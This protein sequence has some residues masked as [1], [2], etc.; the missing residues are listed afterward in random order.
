VGLGEITVEKNRTLPDASTRER[1]ILGTMAVVILFM[2]IASPLFTRRMEP[3]TNVLL[4]Q[5]GGR[6]QNA[7]RPAV[8]STPVKMA[9]APAAATMVKTAGS[10][11]RP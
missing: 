6:A 4:E 7:T 3:A 1:V 8:L 11:V 2:G 10:R 5:M 9:S